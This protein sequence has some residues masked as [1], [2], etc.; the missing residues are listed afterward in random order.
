MV[1][2]E[3]LFGSR[4]SYI[5]RSDDDYVGEAASGFDQT[6]VNVAIIA[7]RD[8]AIS[9][10]CDHF[11]RASNIFGSLFLCE[12]GQKINRET[13]E[14]ETQGETQG[15]LRQFRFAESVTLLTAERE[16]A[17]AFHGARNH[18]IFVL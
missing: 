17:K 12:F 1:G 9:R 14:G 18:K 5:T 11:D 10:D 8:E 2:Y 6:K 13:Q 16:G 3:R 7:P 15:T 4:R